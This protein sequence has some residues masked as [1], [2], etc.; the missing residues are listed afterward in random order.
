MIT[1]LATRRTNV[2]WPLSPEFVPQPEHVAPLGDAVEEMERA[3]VGAHEPRRPC[4]HHVAGLVGDDPRSASASVL[5]DAE[6]PA[7]FEHEEADQVPVR[8]AV[9]VRRDPRLAGL[10]DLQHQIVEDQGGLEGIWRRGS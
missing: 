6:A 8:G 1:S 9:H 3:V 2:S 5:A 7:A 10:V 4:E